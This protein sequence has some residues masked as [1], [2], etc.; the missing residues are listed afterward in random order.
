VQAA[1]VGLKSIKSALDQYQMTKNRYPAALDELFNEKFLTGNREDPWGTPYIYTPQYGD[2]SERVVRY[3]IS[4]AG[5]DR[6]KGTRDDISV[7]DEG[8]DAT[9]RTDEEP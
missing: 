9:T 8:G 3:V 6:R 4:S 2:D 5:P 7:D 1:K